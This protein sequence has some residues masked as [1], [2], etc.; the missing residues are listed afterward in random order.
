MCK[1]SAEI[2]LMAAV[3]IGLVF[4][5]CS[6]VLAQGGPSTMP[7][8]QVSHGIALRDVPFKMP[9]IKPPVFPDRTVDIRD[10]GAVGDG[11]TLNTRSFADAI[12]ACA[13][14]GGGRIVVPAGTWLT[15]PIHL[16]SNINLHIEK[17]AEIRFSTNFKDY[18]PV[19]FT[20]YEGIECYNYSRPGTGLVACVKST[21]GAEDTE[22]IGVPSCAGEKPYL[23]KQIQIP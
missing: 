2:L 4:A 15:G 23:R 20:R 6:A 13:R 9:Q 21:N 1:A 19:V 16:K 17:D 8:K 7:D 18:L 5:G 14:A 12:S 11:K 22:P 3:S 10:Y